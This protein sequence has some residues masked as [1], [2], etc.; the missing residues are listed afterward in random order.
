[1]NSSI[2]QSCRTVAIETRNRKCFLWDWSWKL[3]PYWSVCVSCA[4]YEVHVFVGHMYISK[5][6]CYPI[7]ETNRIAALY[8]LRIAIKPQCMT[9]SC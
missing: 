2:Q 8:L 5:R 3:M 6:A 1:M 9:T 7:C 4:A